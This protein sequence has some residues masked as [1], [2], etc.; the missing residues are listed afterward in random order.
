MT[1]FPPNHYVSAV[2]VASASEFWIG[3]RSSLYESKNG[4][5][6][7]TLDGGKSFLQ[8]FARPVFDLKLSVVHPGGA[9]FLVAA[10]P[11]TD[12]DASSVYLC[13]SPAKAPTVWTAMGSGID[14]GGRRAFYP[15]I[16]L[17]SGVAFVG[18]LT[19]NPRNTSDT[20]SAIFARPIADLIVDGGD[21]GSVGGGAGGAGWSAVKNAPRLD[22]DA[23]PK[24]RS[25]QRRR[26][27][28]PPRPFNYPL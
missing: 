14:W 1:A 10:L 11:W 25:E 18:A 20:S 9:P 23:M 21:G 13:R 6:W 12:D 24:D 27:H 22:I 7:R 19:V 16:A 26:A 17:G 5:I 28:Q 3:V 8:V 4:G 15:T 2:V